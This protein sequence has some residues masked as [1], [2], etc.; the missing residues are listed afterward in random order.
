M[1]AYMFPFRQLLSHENNIFVYINRQQIF[2]MKVLTLF[3]ALLLSTSRGARMPYARRSASAASGVSPS[4]PTVR[5][6]PKATLPP[7]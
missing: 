6:K 4:T 1:Q 5:A 2:Y 3:L 7:P